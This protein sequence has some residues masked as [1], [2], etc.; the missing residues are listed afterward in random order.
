MLVDAGQR[1]GNSVPAG[2]RPRR[3]GFSMGMDE[4]GGPQPRMWPTMQMA[5]RCDGD[6][7]AGESSMATATTRGGRG[8]GQ[9]GVG[10]NGSASTRDRARRLALGIS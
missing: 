4:N 9:M 6:E 8:A 1:A 2:S 10:A 5:Q 7:E 3:Q